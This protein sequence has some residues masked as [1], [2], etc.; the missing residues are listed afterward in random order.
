MRSSLF[1][2]LLP[3]L[4]AS[5]CVRARE[6][7]TAAPVRLESSQELRMT[8]PRSN[9]AAI[10]LRDGRILICGGSKNN[11]VG[12]VLA[13]AELFD[14]KI[15]TFTPT[16]NM[17]VPRAGHT[18]TMLP[19]GRVL[20]VGGQRNVG[21]RSAL[22]SAEIYDPSTGT[23]SPTGSMHVAREGHTA[24]L[25]RDGRVLVAGGSDT[26]W[27]T[28]SSAEIY[29]PEKGKFIPAGDM[30][31]PREAHTATLLRSGK[32]LIAGGGRNFVP[33][34]YIAIDTAEIF[35]PETRRFAFAARMTTDRVGHTATLL[36]DATVLVVGG[37]SSRVTGSHL[38][39]RQLTALYSAETF[40]P[41]TDFFA[42]AGNMRVPRF[43]QTA[44]LLPDGEVLI[45]GGW[46]LAGPVAGGMAE[47]DVY[48]PRLRNFAEAGSM[49]VGR[50]THTATALLDGEVMMAGGV[51]SRGKVLASVEFYDP[52]ERVFRLRPREIPADRR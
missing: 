6:T 9:H 45:A 4:I 16:G 8:T 21:Y 43:L 12:G 36:N 46:H 7:P 13:S 24:T 32:V 38:G 30:T 37:R 41:E 5:A 35:D 50:V 2:L 22:D 11:L 15:G 3:A 47:A 29:D 52:N 49:H 17:T 26:G 28:L 44:T 51:D 10:L 31:S 20:V 40:D 1:A 23:F 19:D 42:R 27:H 39:G 34:G 33:G 14:P 25:M 18:L 48:N